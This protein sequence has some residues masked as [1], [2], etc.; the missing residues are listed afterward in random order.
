MA[1]LINDLK[2]FE[3]IANR[4]VISNYENSKDFVSGSIE[5]HINNL[6]MDQNNYKA[7]DFNKIIKTLQDSFLEPYSKRA[8]VNIDHDLLHRH[9]KSPITYNNVYVMTAFI[10]GELLDYAE[11]NGVNINELRQSCEQELN[12]I[13]ENMKQ[14]DQYFLEVQKLSNLCSKFHR[15]ARA[16]DNK[17]LA[18]FDSIKSILHD[19]TNLIN[20]ISYESDFDYLQKSTILASVG[21]LNKIKDAV[22]EK[23]KAER[24][25][26]NLLTLADS[27]AINQDNLSPVQKTVFDKSTTAKVEFTAGQDVS[28]MILF[29]DKS[30][31]Y[32][33]KNGKYLTASSHGDVRRKISEMYYCSVEYLL[34]KKPKIAKSFQDKMIEREGTP[35]TIINTINRFLENEIL[36][37][38]YLKQDYDAFLRDLMTN[39]SVEVFDDK[40]THIANKQKFQL[41]A[42]SIA[43]NK[44]RHLYDDKSMSVLKEIY[45]NNN[46]PEQLQIYVGKKIA[47]FKTPEEFNQH[48]TKYLSKINGFDLDTILEDISKHGATL[49]SNVN[50]VLIVETTA[51]SQ[52]SNLGSNSWCIVR[53]EGYYDDYAGKGNRQYIVFDF[54]KAS[55]DVESMI[56]ITLNPDGTYRN[57]HV[58]NDDSTDEETVEQFTDVIVMAQRETFPQLDKYLEERLYPEIKRTNKLKMA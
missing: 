29:A 41:F 48:L 21:N 50:D 52:M 18:M 23:M 54:T 57:A 43:S 45:D 51:Y 36:V 35:V 49:V 42:Y 32:R 7:I 33:E 28:G 37:K 6:V 39:K 58:K 44:Y 3:M 16:D 13:K 40:F 4:K 14:L 38:N 22:I 26:N 19:K 27:Y 5:E 8:V 31:C 15:I 2:E 9:V 1:D 24:T 30:V 47:A 20:T 56:G 11:N 46:D 53:D 12:N 34:R 25:N 10:M 17:G 55:S